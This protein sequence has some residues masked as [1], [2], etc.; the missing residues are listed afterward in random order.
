MPYH[1]T[2]NVQ[3]IMV[4]DAITEAEKIAEVLARLGI[5]STGPPTKRQSKFELDYVFDVEVLVFNVQVRA[6]CEAIY[7][8]R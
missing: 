8:R 2:R 4:D 3:I 7:V 6:E 1:I 5:V